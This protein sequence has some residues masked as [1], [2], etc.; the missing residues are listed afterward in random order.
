[1]LMGCTVGWATTKTAEKISAM[2]QSSFCNRMAVEFNDIA[3]INN[4]IR[5]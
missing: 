2:V 1:M 5:K 4:S 3:L